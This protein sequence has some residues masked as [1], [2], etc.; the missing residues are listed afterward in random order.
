MAQPALLL[1]LLL[2]PRP[3]LRL[4]LVL[5]HLPLLR[6]ECVQRRDASGRPPCLLDLRSRWL[7]ERD[8]VLPFDAQGRGRAV[9]E[10]GARARHLPP[11]LLPLGP[12][13]RARHAARPLCRRGPSPRPAP[14]HPLDAQAKANAALP[15]RVR[16]RTGRRLLLVQAREK[17]TARRRRHGPLLPRRGRDQDAR[18]ARRRSRGH[19]HTLLDGL[20]QLGLKLPR[21]RRLAVGS[22]GPLV[23]AAVPA[24][25]R[26]ALDD[27]Q[28]LEP[29]QQGQ[30][31]WR[32]HA[33]APRSRGPRLG[34]LGDMMGRMQTR[35]TWIVKRDV[36]AWTWVD[37]RSRERDAA[38]EARRSGGVGGRGPDSD[39]GLRA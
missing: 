6:Q 34:E 30:E 23:L 4:P 3:R 18:A 12:Q 16:P 2:R 10:A 24:A 8:R 32:R 26:R 29:E 31:P 22:Q 21:R 25:P 20:A 13:D 9:A 39:G 38:G 1:L 14:R 11:P 5:P 33:H 35:Q 17:E 27:A 36:D 15:R 7:Q 28:V 37:Q 19:R